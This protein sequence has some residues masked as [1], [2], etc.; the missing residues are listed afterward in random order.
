MTVAMCKITIISYSGK[1]FFIFLPTLPHFYLLPEVTKMILSIDIRGYENAVIPSHPFYNVSFICLC[2][3]CYSAT[4]AFF[5]VTACIEKYLLSD[6][7]DVHGG[8]MVRLIVNE[9][10][11]CVFGRKRYVDFEID[12]NIPGKG[13]V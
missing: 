6:F 2:V 4:M 9:H 5:E 10:R 8:M 11:F 12:G 1:T 3:A 13:G 7:K